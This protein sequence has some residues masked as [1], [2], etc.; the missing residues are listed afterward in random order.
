MVLEAQVYGSIPQEMARDAAGPPWDVPRLQTA[1]AAA[2]RAAAHH[3]ADEVI[4]RTTRP[5]SLGAWRAL[6]PFLACLWIDTASFVLP[7]RRLWR[8]WPPLGGG[9]GWWPSPRP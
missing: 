3:D 6:R 8:L 1:M 7:H 2:E 9:S 5:H 4:V